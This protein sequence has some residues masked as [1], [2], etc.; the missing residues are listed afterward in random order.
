MLGATWQRFGSG[1]SSH[2]GCLQCADGSQNKLKTLL[3]P[4]IV[5]LLHPDQSLIQFGQSQQFMAGLEK[6][7]FVWRHKFNVTASG[8]RKPNWADGPEGIREV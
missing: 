7:V 5:S 6:A 1:I 3:M 8:I 4:D 2:G